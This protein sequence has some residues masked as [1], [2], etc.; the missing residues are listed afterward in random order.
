MSAAGSVAANG[1]AS[2][3]VTETGAESVTA[4]ATKTRAESVTANVNGTVTATSGRV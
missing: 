3:A 2:E 4:N 1:T